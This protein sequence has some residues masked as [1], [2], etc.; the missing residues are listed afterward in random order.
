MLGGSRMRRTIRHGIVF[1][2]C[3]TDR[4]SPAPPP[5]FLNRSRPTPH[6]PNVGLRMPRA[7]SPC[8]SPLLPH[9]SGA[10]GARRIGLLMCV[11]AASG[12]MCGCGNT[13]QRTATEQL[14]LSDSVDRAVRAIDFS[15]ISGL[16]CW[17]DTS[18]IK[19]ASKP[20]SYVND[21]Y[22]ISS[23][24]NQLAAAGCNLVSE[25]DDAEVVVEARVGTLGS[26]HHEVTYGFP[27]NNLLSQAA[28]FVPT[29]PPIPPLPDIAVAQKDDQTGAMKLAVFAYDAATGSAIW[30]SGIA[31]AQSNGRETWF[32]GIGPFQSGTIYEKPR[33]FGNRLRVPLLGARDRATTQQQVTL[34]R[35]Y[36]FGRT[37]LASDPDRGR[38]ITDR[39]SDNTARE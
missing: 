38:Q 35:P 15:P 6:S 8:I 29:A 1:R 12:S 34:Q 19:P 20:T 33:L 3:Q 4:Y 30:Q 26:D 23:L 25:R 7:E 24:R 27:S 36:D 31:T 11:L 39:P 21:G 5:G 22:I 2:V 16:D 18:N 10:A 13:Q 9:W 37:Q 28:V 32:L 17:L 14:V